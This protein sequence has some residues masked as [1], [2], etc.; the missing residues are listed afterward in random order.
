[1]DGLLRS[2]YESIKYYNW[3]EMVLCKTSVVMR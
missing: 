3:L 1:M 2:W